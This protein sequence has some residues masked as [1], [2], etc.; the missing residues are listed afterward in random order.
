[1]EEFQKYFSQTTF[2]H[3][4]QAR[5][6][7]LTGD[8]RVEFV[9]YSVLKYKQGFPRDFSVLGNLNEPFTFV[10]KQIKALLTF[11]QLVSKFHSILSLFAQPYYVP[12]K[13]V[14]SKP[15]ENPILMSVST[16]LEAKPSLK[17]R[18]AN[19]I[20]WIYLGIFRDNSLKNNFFRNK[21]F[22]KIES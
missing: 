20:F 6:S 2:H 19:T 3:H 11:I 13:M 18:N 15:A 21:T 12:Y 7:I 10:S 5:Y 9:I 8:T 16:W 14:Y 17:I 22:F 4:F 1:M